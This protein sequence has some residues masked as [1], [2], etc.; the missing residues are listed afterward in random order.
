MQSDRE[1]AE[2]G[3]GNAGVADSD[4]ARVVAPI[5]ALHAAAQAALLPAIVAEPV[6][7]SR[8]GRG[9][10]RGHGRGRGRGV[11]APLAIAAVAAEEDGGRDMKRR[12]L[13]A[14]WSVGDCTDVPSTA[15]VN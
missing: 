10:E 7:E 4:A 3:G 9:R 11:A 1:P 5:V 6:L 13:E 14:A 15:I 8:G 2:G 12:R